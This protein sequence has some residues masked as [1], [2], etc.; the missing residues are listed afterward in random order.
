L[1]TPLFQDIPMFNTIKTLTA[2]AALLAIAG[3]A[4]ANDPASR[5]IY[6]SLVCVAPLPCALQ[7]LVYD[8]L[9]DCQ[10]SIAHQSR[11]TSGTATY[12]CVQKTVPAWQ[13]AE[14]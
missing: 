12:S 13:P 3:A 4:Q 7:R 9:A 14:D 8:S 1:V 6:G 5:T 11:T 2:A 10:R